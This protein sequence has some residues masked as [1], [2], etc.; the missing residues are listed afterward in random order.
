MMAYCK[1]VIYWADKGFDQNE[2]GENVERCRNG[3]TIV[4][5]RKYI[6]IFKISSQQKMLFKKFKKLNFGFF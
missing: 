2:T 3:V 6:Y 5:M 4:V 1:F